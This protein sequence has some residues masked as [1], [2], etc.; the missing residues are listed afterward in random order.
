MSRI[1]KAIGNLCH[2]EGATEV[3]VSSSVL[4]HAERTIS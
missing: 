2:D 1:F 4:A 3:E